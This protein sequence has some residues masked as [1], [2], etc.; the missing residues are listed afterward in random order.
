M[1]FIGFLTDVPIQHGFSF[2]GLKFYHEGVSLR[3]GLSLQAF[4]G[5][6]T[7]INSVN[8]SVNKKA[9]HLLPIAIGTLRL[10]NVNMK[11]ALNNYINVLKLSQRLGRYDFVQQ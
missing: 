6:H 7:F 9:F 10:F 8:M 1:V 11:I 5:F 2:E 4:C 3:A